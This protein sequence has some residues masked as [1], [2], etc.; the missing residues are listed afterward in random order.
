MD[1]ISGFNS[2]LNAYFTYGP[3]SSKRTDIL[4]DFIEKMIINTIKNKYGELG[5]YTIKKE[6]A[7][8][9]TTKSGQ[10]KCDVVLLKGDKPLIIFPIKNCMS[11]YSQNCYN[12]WENLTGEV[13][14]LK[15][16]N[17]DVYIIPVNV[18][19]NKIPYL[20]KDNTIKHWEII[21]YD[22]SFKIYENLVHNNL[23]H[24]NYNVILNV[25]HICHTNENFDKSPTIIGVEETKSFDEIL[26]EII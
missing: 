24:N 25:N 7:V 14:H 5:E 26:N 9:S 22:N 23:V 18:L 15:W 13:S 6:Y 1:T 17:P 4:N 8:K 12:Y 20:K 21:N 11:N 19:M 16:A 10:K 2:M 3:R